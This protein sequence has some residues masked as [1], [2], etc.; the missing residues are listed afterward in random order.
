MDTK[1]NE[2]QL[3][4]TAGAL[5]RY[6]NNNCECTIEHFHDPNNNLKYNLYVHPT[7]GISEFYY[8][9]A[10]GLNRSLQ[11]RS[12]PSPPP[13][14]E[15]FLSIDLHNILQKDYES[16]Q[17]ISNM[18][19]LEIFIRDNGFFFPI[20]SDTQIDLNNL[21]QYLQY[22]KILIDLHFKLT[23]SDLNYN[24]IFS[25]MMILHLMPK[26]YKEDNPT[27][28]PLYLCW[29][30]PQ[31]MLPQQDAS[32]LAGSNSSDHPSDMPGWN[33]Y[34]TIK[35]ETIFIPVIDFPEKNEYD[36]EVKTHFP[37]C[38]LMNKCQFLYIHYPDMPSTHLCRRVIDFLYNYTHS[39]STVSIPDKIDYSFKGNFTSVLPR[40][41]NIDNLPLVQALLS[42]AADTVKAEFDHI[43]QNMTITYDAQSKRPFWKIPNLITALV[44]SAFYMDRETTLLRHCEN[45]TCS[46]YFRV[47]RT[48]S[49]RKYCCKECNDIV[50]QRRQR[51]KK[52]KAQ[53]ALPSST[54][55]DSSDNTSL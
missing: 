35:N 36:E 55:S 28:Y 27:Q 34:D 16:K 14:L 52:I 31:A 37:D 53:S 11:N 9:T 22:I 25:D 40:K 20:S 42:I 44:L 48:N 7:Q 39:L 50:Q 33:V 54:A 10:T 49:K 23:E 1:I 2:N 26:P 47:S 17:A 21:V 24:A 5:F 18:K 4:E 51:L 30:T 12:L 38:A 41:N 43:L 19:K 15:A 3:I 29:E 45:I 46:N 13:V 6:K 32:D 8:K